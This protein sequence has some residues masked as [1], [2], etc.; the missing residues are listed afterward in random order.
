M[1]PVIQVIF[2][3]QSLQKWVDD[4]IAESTQR[5]ADFDT[6]I[7]R[8]QKQLAAA[9][10]RSTQGNSAR[11]EWR[12]C[13]SR[14][15]ATD[16]HCPPAAK[17]LYRTVPARR[18]V[19]NLDRDRG[20]CDGRD[21]VQEC[22]HGV[23]LD[24][25]RSTHVHDH[26]GTAQ[27]VLPANAA[28]GFGRLRPEQQQ[29]IDEPL[30]LRSGQRRRRSAGCYGPGHRRT[31]ENALLP[32]RAAWICW[33]LLLVSLLVA[34]LAGFLISRLSKALKRANRKAMEEMSKLYTILRKPSAA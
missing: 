24:L 21:A 19:Q 12:H 31:A 4:S 5:I 6:Q 16:A 25:G 10:Q 32:D 26:A 23:Q 15:R 11:A 28:D 14:Y 1:Y 3:G 7:D 22:L 9:S 17:T 29:R 13:E 8:E 30:Y 27:A 2:R 18:S 33:R 34:P 20:G